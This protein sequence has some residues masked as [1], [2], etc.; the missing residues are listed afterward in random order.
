MYG[1]N[2]FGDYPN[3]MGVE[4]LT[5]RDIDCSNLT[6]VSVEFYRWLGVESSTWDH[7]SF[8]ATNDGVNWVTVWE[9]TGGAISDSS[10]TFQSFDISAIADNQPLVRLRWGMGPTDGSVTYPGWNI[11]D[12]VIKAVVP[13]GCPGDINGD[14][15]IDLDDLSILLSNFGN[16]GAGPTDGDID[17][18]GDVDLTDLSLM[19]DVFGTQCQ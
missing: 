12:I 14:G 4:Y 5:T 19:L 3:N 7:A 16:T 1:Y 17:G 18:D 15:Q 9:H 10:W 6:Q 2:L 13:I 8:E 11:D